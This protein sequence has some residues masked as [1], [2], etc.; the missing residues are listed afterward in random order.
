MQREVGL[1][2][3]P[4]RKQAVTLARVFT[5]VLQE[6]LVWAEL[7]VSKP[8]LKQPVMSIFTNGGH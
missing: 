7:S 4:L 3:V 8:E 1:M 5:V 2:L 6:N